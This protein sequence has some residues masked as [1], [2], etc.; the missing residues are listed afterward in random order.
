M[1]TIWLWLYSRGGSKELWAWTF[2]CASRIFLCVYKGILF[3]NLLKVSSLGVGGGLLGDRSTSWTIAFLFF[4]LRSVHYLKNFRVFSGLLYSSKSSHS[5]EN[6]LT[7]ASEKIS[8][9]FGR[10]G[11]TWSLTLVIFKASDR[12]WHYW[13]FPQNQVVRNF[14]LDISLTLLFLSVRQLQV[15]LDRKP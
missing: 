9:I 13:C 14:R 5:T 3:S 15:L 4:F 12:V 8:W 7:V 10:Y 6:P 1:Q 2:L 11:A